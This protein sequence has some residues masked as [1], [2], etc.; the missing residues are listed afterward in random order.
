LLLLLLLIQGEF[1]K[2]IGG[3]ELFLFR[4][5]RRRCR[6]CCCRSFG[7]GFLLPRLERMLG[8]KRERSQQILVVATF[9][10]PPSM[11]M[12]A[13]IG[14]SSLGH[15]LRALIAVHA[16]TTTT[17]IATAWL[18]A[19]TLLLHLFA[20][21]RSGRNVT[22]STFTITTGRRR[23]RCIILGSFLLLYQMLL[24]ELKARYIRYW[25]QFHVR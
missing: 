19:T 4:F 10:Y 17:A 18:F 15:F 14:V 20:I 6:C 9:P 5:E 23:I 12:I 16:T 11:M 3:Q 2:G 24:I 25:F 8:F 21:V 13:M 7:L 22:S 1:G